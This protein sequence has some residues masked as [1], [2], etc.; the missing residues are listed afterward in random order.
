MIDTNIRVNDWQKGAAHEHA[1][2]DAEL[3]NLTFMP[4]FH[5]LPAVKTMFQA[6]LN[7][8]MPVPP[9]KRFL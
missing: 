3:P 1:N 4:D 9:E 6:G 8:R 7:G 2:L 5:M